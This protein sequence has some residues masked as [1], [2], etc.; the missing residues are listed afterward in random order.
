MWVLGN[1]P[2]PLEEQPV[3]SIAKPPLQP[4]LARFLILLQRPTALE[5]LT[6]LRV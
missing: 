6:T 1:E 4:Q 5:L 2:D 3:L